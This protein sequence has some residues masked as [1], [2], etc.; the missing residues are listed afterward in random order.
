MLKHRRLRILTAIAC[1]CVGVSL[2]AYAA[3]MT[4]EQK[5]VC[6]NCNAEHPHEFP[7]YPYPTSGAVS[8]F[9]TED[10]CDMW[11]TLINAPLDLDELVLAC[12]EDCEINP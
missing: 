9:S 12:S 1:L 10:C 7:H 8:A 11:C 4:H 6:A 2:V 5:V 3:T